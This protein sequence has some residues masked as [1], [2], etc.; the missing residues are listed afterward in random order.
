V[1]ERTGNRHPGTA[2]GNTYQGSDGTWLIASVPGDAIFARL[3]NLVGHPEWI[4]DPANRDP[5]ARDANAA[6][7]EAGVAAWV[8]ARPGAEAARQMSEAGVP[9]NR[10]NTVADVV[11]DD[12]VRYR[13]S[14][15]THTD[16]RLGQVMMAAPAPRLGRTPGSIRR[17]APWPGRD[18]LA[19]LSELGL[20]EDAVTRLRDEGVVSTP[21]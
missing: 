15:T 21:A 14:F 18:S 12:L 20:E 17:S 6:L 10:V 4:A 7:L 5:V 16:E 11:D 2:P 13:H 3:A 9:A 19:I 1:R 8:A